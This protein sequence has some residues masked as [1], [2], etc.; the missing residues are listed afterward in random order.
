MSDNGTRPKVIVAD[1]EGAIAQTMALILNAQG[2]NARPVSSGEA[3]VEM[4]GEFKPDFLIS[5]I[6]MGNLDG[7]EAAIRVR[8]KWPACKVLV[9]SATMVD[10]ETQNRLKELGFDFLRKP[11]HP[12]QLLAHLRKQF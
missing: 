5:D 1:D 11:L 9:F 10:L 8:E 7:I 3:A 6:R 2:F 4:A 12:S